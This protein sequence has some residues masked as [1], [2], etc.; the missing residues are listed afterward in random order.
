MFP[1]LFIHSPSLIIALTRM[2]CY[3]KPWLNMAKSGQ[4]SSKH[5]SQ[6]GQ[7]CLPKTGLS[8]NILFFFFFMYK[9][10]IL[11]RYNSI[12]RFNSDLSRSVRPRRK[13]TDVQHYHH[14][15]KS[16]SVSSSS[17]ASPSSP[18]ICLPTLSGSSFQPI[19]ENSEAPYHFDAFSTSWSSSSSVTS[20]DLPSFRS[21]P[22]SYDYNNMQDSSN[23]ST[24]SSPPSIESA[25]QSFDMSHT[26]PYSQSPTAS[27][28][29]SNGLYKPFTNHN[30]IQ[31]EQT[32]PAYSQFPL[33]HGSN[34][35]SADQFAIFGGLSSTPI[36]PSSVIGMQCNWDPT[37]SSSMTGGPKAPSDNGYKVPL[38]FGVRTV[39]NFDP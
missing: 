6:A 37:L 2:K 13:S 7:V 9:L 12:T 14:S 33:I 34:D 28:L 20:E 11:T 30:H 16:E 5:T 35:D 36:D 17:S 10:K 1:T 32:Y 27:G 39:M 24:S 29:H 15:R 31:H 25:Y 19:P 22:I 18:P 38:N 3:Y 26:L 23:A 8:I 4:R 21:S